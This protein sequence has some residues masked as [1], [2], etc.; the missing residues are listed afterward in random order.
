MGTGE[1]KPGMKRRLF[2]R[3]EMQRQGPADGQA[4]STMCASFRDR[5]CVV[6]NKTNWPAKTKDTGALLELFH[7]PD[8]GQWV[9]ECLQRQRMKGEEGWL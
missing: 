5:H 8:G 9:A 4:D 2:D 1:G 3:S 7:S 6:V